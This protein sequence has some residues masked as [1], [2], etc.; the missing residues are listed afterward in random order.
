MAKGVLEN[1]RAELVYANNAYAEQGTFDP[2][3]DTISFVTIPDLT[4][5]TTI[6]TEGTP[7]TAQALSLTTV[8]LAT[9]QYGETVEITDVA[10][11]KSPVELVSIATERLSRQAAE[12]VDKVVRDVIAASGTP[13]YALGGSTNVVRSDL[14]STE[15]AVGADLIRLARTMAKNKIKPFADGLYR[16]WCHPSVIYDL[17]KDTTAT[18]GW[19][20]QLK[21]TDPDP[22]NKGQIGILN[23]FRVFEATNGPTFASTTT[24]YA[25][26][27][28]GRTKGWAVGDLQ[29]LSVHHV[30]PGGDHT[31]P[32]AQ[33]EILGYK[34]N[35]GAAALSN[36]YYYRLETAGTTL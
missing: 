1:L 14:A 24:V 17:Q 25:S 32:L 2:G 33:K 34:V 21:Y 36:S 35:F 28:V 16:I 22:L 26:I 23:G 18:T 8:T 20:D 19:R 3:H 29:T 7:P 30:T 11:V 5:S 15:I 27:A 13:L 12:S 4:L 31:D 9:A 6:L 10:K